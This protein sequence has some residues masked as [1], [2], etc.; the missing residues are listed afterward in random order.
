[1]SSNLFRLNA[2]CVVLGTDMVRQKKYVAST[3]ADDLIFPVLQLN[4][5][6]IKSI[7]LSLINFL[8]SKLPYVTDI[9]LIPQL[10]NINSEYIVSQPDDLNI[11]YGFLVDHK[12]QLNELHWIEFDDFK[13]IQYSNII[14]EV[15]QKLY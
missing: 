6:N 13:P 5:D 3:S 1:M 11:I 10:I 2:H 12:Q 7:N 15:I 8:H 4:Q 9:E 14:F